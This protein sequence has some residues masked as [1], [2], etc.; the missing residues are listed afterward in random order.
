[1]RPF[2]LNISKLKYLRKL[3][4]EYECEDA[5]TKC[6]E[7]KPERVYKP[8]DS[9]INIRMVERFDN[10]PR[11]LQ[12]R[13]GTTRIYP[14]VNFPIILSWQKS[15][16]VIDVVF[17][18]VMVTDLCLTALGPATAIIDFGT[19]SNGTYQ[20]NFQNGEIRYSGELIVSSDSYTINFPANS[21][22]NFRNSPLNKIPEHTIW[23]LVGYH[24]EETAPLVQLF[25]AALMELGAEEKSFTPGYYTA[26]EIDNS[27]DII[28]PN[29]HGF[30]FAQPFIFYFSGDSSDLDEF[31]RQWSY[32]YSEYMH[33]WIRTDK[34]E[35]FLSWMHRQ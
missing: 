17:E 21:A 30:W 13:F 15:S 27:G 12:M 7:E 1:M 33:V 19:L 35:E 10:Y 22:F 8:I 23:G 9:E 18:Y 3:K 32:K 20:L 29:N 14:C 2:L 4:Y 5:D 31:L 6:N 24:R 11:T 34:G 28:R 26:F 25:F 16:N